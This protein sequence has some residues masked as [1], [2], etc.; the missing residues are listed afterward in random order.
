MKYTFLALVVLFMACGD[1]DNNNNN[2]ELRDPSAI[3]P[4]EEAIPDTM[5]IQQ[6]SLITPDTGSRS[7][8]TNRP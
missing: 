8:T 1:G 4:P 5:T 7:D 6:D 2:P 3:Q